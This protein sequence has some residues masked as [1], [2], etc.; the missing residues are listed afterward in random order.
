ML[1]MKAT[2]KLLQSIP[3]DELTG[4]IAVPIYQTSTFIQEAP[5]VNKGYDYSRSG[6]PTR[7]ALETIV[8]ELEG[9]EVGLAFS[10]GLAAIDAVLR[11]LSSGDEVIAVDDIYGGAFRLFEKVYRKFGVS[12]RYVDTTDLSAVFD[13]ITPR[14]RLIWLETPTNP[15]LKISDIAAIAR[16]A[17]AHNVCLCV[18]NTFASPAGQ[19]PLHCRSGRYTDP[20][21]WRTNQ[22]LPECLRGG[23]GALRQ[24]S[25][26]PRNRNPSPTGS[27]SKP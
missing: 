5:G 20:G 24:L 10:S 27:G 6:N 26:D 14:T 7:Q 4:A 11:L 2:T 9:G 12:V 1:Y 23:V 18:D 19:L 15:T 21:A 25:P 17:H 8:A 16:L 22:V 13:A 3:V